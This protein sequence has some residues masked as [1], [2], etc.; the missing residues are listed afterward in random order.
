MHTEFIFSLRGSENSF[1]LLSIAFP[2][3]SVDHNS[4]KTV[5]VD[6]DDSKEQEGDWVKQFYLIPPSFCLYPSAGS[7][8]QLLV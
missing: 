2:R 8:L 5:P 4:C 1:S 7:V 3:H 6:Q